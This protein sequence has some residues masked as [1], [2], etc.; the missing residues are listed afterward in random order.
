MN[1]KDSSTYDE[2]QR[3]SERSWGLNSLAIVA[4]LIVRYW[5]VRVD[6]I[7]FHTWIRTMM[8][9]WTMV[10]TIPCVCQIKNPN[11]GKNSK[12]F[13]LT[14]R[15]RLHIETDEMTSTNTQRTRL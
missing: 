9:S 6:R 10:P 5:L 2:V 4:M 1:G 12:M 15:A 14:E 11:A 13:I 8:K 3:D 7:D